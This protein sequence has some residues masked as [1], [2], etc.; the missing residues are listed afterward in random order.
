MLV[1]I[2]IGFL[3]GLITALSPCVLP[4]LPLLLAGGASSGS[5]SRPY[6]IVAGLVLS[7]TFFTLA[8][9]WLLN[10]FGLP[11]DLLR[12]LAIVLLLLLAATLLVPRLA[13][14]LERP[15]LPLTRRRVGTDRSGLVLGMSLGLVFV[16]CAGPVLA[17][18]T[19]VSASGQIGRSTI[20]V[21]SS[22][23]LGAALPMLAF[24]I[25]GQRLASGLRL[26]RTHAEATR[27][28]AGVVLGLTAVAIALGVDRHF[29][30]ALPGYTASLQNRIERSSVAQ[31]ELRKLRSGGVAQAAAADPG[32]RAPEFRGIVRWL[33]TPGG[34]PLSL[35]KLR[36]KVVL[37]DFWTYS[38]IN[39][40]R[41]LPHL[42]AWDDAYRKD[43]LV[44]IGVHTPEFAFERVPS[45]VSSAVRRL[46]IRY[47]VALDNGYRTWNA[48]QNEYWPAEYLIDR[49][50]QIRHTHFG[51]GE[52]GETESAIRR[53]LGERVHTP[54]TAIVDTAPSEVTTPESYLGY[55]RI[56]RFHG[57]LVEDRVAQYRFPRSLPIDG[58]AYAGAWRVEPA[59]IVAGR[60]ARLRLRF[61]ARAVYLVLAGRGSVAAL[62]DGHRLRTVRVAETPR[63]YTI[64]SNPRRRSG[65][66]E[67]RFSPGLSAYS[68]TFG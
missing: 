44:I 31:K 21:T 52:Y 11:Q 50:G 26:L 62:V 19:A 5:R 61:R 68:F 67:L 14:L 65:L 64:A 17:A 28:T 15:L 35:A 53:L 34:A 20:V 10:L 45:N 51:E 58:L 33:N 30:T 9:A 37:V 8:G 36:G 3:A 47:P 55:V 7:F 39:C 22:Y 54:R 49:T 4:V 23:A 43:G 66:L 40:L 60:N 63:L 32:A 12:N 25:G 59:R 38:C 48:Y 46:G 57:R 29:T 16:P 56:E 42:K 27:R 6:A 2:G 1:L 24:A 41:A 13:F 18:M